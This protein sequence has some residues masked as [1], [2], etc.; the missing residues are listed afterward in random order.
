METPRPDT[1]VDILYTRLNPSNRDTTLEN[2]KHQNC[3]TQEKDR[4]SLTFLGQSP[5][6]LLH[7]PHKTSFSFGH[8]SN[9]SLI[10]K[11]STSRHQPKSI[12]CSCG[13]EGP[14]RR[15]TSLDVSFH[16]LMLSDRRDGPECWR[17]AKSALDLSDGERER[18]R[19][20]RG[21]R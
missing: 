15:S 19:V 2:K 21:G 16:W 7:P 20:W 1:Y 9:N 14:T 17:R 4:I 5:V 13:H 3:I 8:P 10:T 6:S 12:V 18:S 11:L